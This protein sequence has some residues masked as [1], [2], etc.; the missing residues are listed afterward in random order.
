[1]FVPATKN[2]AEIKQGTVRQACQFAD[3]KPSPH[4][5]G[6]SQQHHRS[7]LVSELALSFRFRWCD[8]L[9]KLLNCLPTPNP[10]PFL[11]RLAVEF[12]EEEEW[13]S[14]VKPTD[15]GSP[16]L[17]PECSFSVGSRHKDLWRHARSYGDQANVQGAVKAVQKFE[18]IYLRKEQYYQWIDD[19]DLI[20]SRNG[21]HHAKAPFPRGWKVSFR[22]PEGFHYD[23]KHLEQRKFSITDFEGKRYSL[24]ANGYVNMDP[25]GYVRD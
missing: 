17:L 7:E 9:V 13:S 16:L 5:F 20:F 11:E 3:R 2:T 8:Q 10:V 18:Q 6:F 14:R 1:M 15:M 12:A 22:L 24:V 21:P 25:H 23:I 19:R 4:I